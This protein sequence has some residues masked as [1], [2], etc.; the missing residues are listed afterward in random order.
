[1]GLGF[2]S[3]FIAKKKIDIFKYPITNRFE[4]DIFIQIDKITKKPVIHLLR[5]MNL[6][7]TEIIR[8]LQHS[9]FFLF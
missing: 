6:S 5:E 4:D 9:D 3:Y 2:V 7:E 8:S 1:M